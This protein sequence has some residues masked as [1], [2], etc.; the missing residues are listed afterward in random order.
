MPNKKKGNDKKGGG[1][2]NTWQKDEDDVQAIV[3][4]D[5]FNRK[6]TPITQELPRVSYFFNVLDLLLQKINIKLFSHLI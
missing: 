4:A 6:F 3:V 1:G 2:G 5:S